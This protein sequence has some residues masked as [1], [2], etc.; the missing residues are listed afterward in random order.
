MENFL[1]LCKNALK[2]LEKKNFYKSL[3]YYSKILKIK[4]NFAESYYHR[5]ICYESINE[6]ELAIQD[7]NKAIDLKNNFVEAYYNR[8]NLLKDL[9]RFEDAI[10]DY[11]IVIKLQPTFYKAYW[12]KA[13]LLLLKENF[14]DGLKM[15]EFRFNAF[16]INKNFW[17]KM[18]SGKENLKNKKILIHHEQGLGDIIMYSR[19]VYLFKELGAYVIYKIPKK[20][21]FLLNGIAGVDEFV[22][23]DDLLEKLKFDF[24][25]P[26]LS[27]PFLFKINLQKK[28][29][30]IPYIIIDNIISDKWKKHIANN[31]FKIGICWQGSEKN[32]SLP[33]KLFKD[34]AKIDNVRLIS[35]Q[36]NFDLIEFK[37]CSHQFNIERLPDNFDS[38]DA[39][40]VDTAAVVQSL[41]L[42]IS[43][44]TSVSHLSG[45]LGIKTFL[46]IETFPHWYWFLNKK[47]CL[48]Y[49]NHTLFRQKKMNVWEDVFESV[50][51]EVIKLALN[52]KA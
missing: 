41:D 39:A 45:A 43:C 38:G 50:K 10:K 3:K 16:S 15:F 19:Y 46:L 29:F 1:L 31:G 44:D 26:L 22:F 2:E 8:A 13:N 21:K 7:L 24:F 17:K 20:L 30:K 37:K 25:C 6:K 51:I 28:I 9:M 27:I 35:L 12:N 48:W 34:I 47:D 5:S 52:K 11:D 32:K 23:E 18:W 49:P 4:P 42:V 40:F 36:K 14:N 33:L